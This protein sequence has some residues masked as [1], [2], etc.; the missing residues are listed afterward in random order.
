MI[1]YA[2]RIGTELAAGLVVGVGSGI[3]IDQWLGTKPWGLLLMFFLGAGAGILNVYRAINGLGYA[4]GYQGTK[5][6]GD[7]GQKPGC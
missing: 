6:A 3:L 5:S 4:T 7:D 2:F 1:S